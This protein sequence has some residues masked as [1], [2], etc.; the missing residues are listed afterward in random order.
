M[1]I[2]SLK[3]FKLRNVELANVSGGTGCIVTGVREHKGQTWLDYDRVNSA[4]EVL[5]SHCD[6][7]DSNWTSG[8]VTV[9]MEI[10]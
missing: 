2:E 4:G 9:G 8:P 3:E 6:E 5:S 1:K 7:P 10:C